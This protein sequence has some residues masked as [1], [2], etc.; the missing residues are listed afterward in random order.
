MQI[1]PVSSSF[2]SILYLSN[3]FDLK[4][5]VALLRRLPSDHPQWS[6]IEEDLFKYK[7]GYQGEKSLRASNFL[8][9]NGTV[10][11]F[12]IIKKSPHLDFFLYSRFFVQIPSNTN[13]KN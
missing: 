10:H 3:I 9:T 11:S 12:N 6:R 13:H 7:A 2:L 4:A 8:I 5:D 1:T